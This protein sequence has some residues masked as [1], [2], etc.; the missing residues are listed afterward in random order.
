MSRYNRLRRNNTNFMKTTRSKFR[1]TVELT[2]PPGE[3]GPIC[4][5]SPYCSPDDSERN[6]K[7]WRKAQIRMME[8]NLEGL[9]RDQEAELINTWILQLVR[10]ELTVYLASAE[11]RLKR[12]LEIEL[13]VPA[14]EVI[15][16]ALELRTKR[17]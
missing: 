15:S 13:G 3:V 12:P 16:V 9:S 2:L 4:S 8:D 17:R 7:V 5:Y 10:R 14:A 6:L 1:K 11:K